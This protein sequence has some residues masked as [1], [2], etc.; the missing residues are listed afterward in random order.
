[1]LPK[2]NEPLINRYGISKMP[3]GGVSFEII[4]LE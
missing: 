4:I 1:M 3:G 2:V